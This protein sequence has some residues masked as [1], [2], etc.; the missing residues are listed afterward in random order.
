MTFTIIWGSFKLLQGSAAFPAI[1]SLCSLHSVLFLRDLSVAQCGFGLRVFHNFLIWGGWRPALFLFLYLYISCPCC[2]VFC[3]LLAC[4]HVCSAQF[5]MW[6][7]RLLQFYTCLC[8]L[9]P[10]R[11]KVYLY[12]HMFDFHFHFLYIMLF[13]SLKLR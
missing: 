13:H 7:F 9:C 2:M 8:I 6:A 4:C 3:S 12:L 11:M 5:S 10:C 1:L